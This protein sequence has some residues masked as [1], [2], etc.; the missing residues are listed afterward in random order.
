LQIYILDYIVQ[1]TNP[2]KKRT[3]VPPSTRFTTI[4]RIQL[5]QDGKIPLDELPSI[6]L[7]PSSLRSGI[8]NGIRLYLD[9]VFV[10]KEL[11][12]SIIHSLDGTVQQRISKQIGKY[13]SDAFVYV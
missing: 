11:V 1:G 12:K 3:D 4:E 13:S 2:K 10:D 8:L 6:Q 9:G 7:D 5:L